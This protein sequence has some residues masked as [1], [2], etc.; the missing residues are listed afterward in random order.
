M[1]KLAQGAKRNTRKTELRAKRRNLTAKQYANKK[2]FSRA[3]VKQ[4]RNVRAGKVGHVAKER[5][6]RGVSK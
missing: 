5:K 1:S 4:S 2:A 3:T 6:V